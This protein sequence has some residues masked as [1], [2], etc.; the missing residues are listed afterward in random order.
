MT[1]VHLRILRLL[2]RQRQR[3]L[4]EHDAAGHP[5]ASSG[6]RRHELERSAGRTRANVAAAEARRRYM[7]PARGQ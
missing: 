2:A 5:D 7:R 4:D 6:G 1:D 3:E